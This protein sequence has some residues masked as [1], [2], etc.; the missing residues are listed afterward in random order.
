VNK[1]TK[2]PTTGN[3]DDF[4]TVIEV[5][6][7]PREVFKAINNPRAWWPEEIEGGTEQLNDEFTYHYKDIH[8]RRIKLIEIIPDKKVV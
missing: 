5:N 8:N 3:N 2:I 7:S 1:D 6:N 4:T